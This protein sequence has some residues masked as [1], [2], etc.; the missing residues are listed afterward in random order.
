MKNLCCLFLALLLFASCASKSMDSQKKKEIAVATQRLGG[1]YYNSGNYTAALKT[2]LEAQETIPNDPYLNN[3]IGLVYLAKERYK[4]A[5]DSFKT[6]LTN[7]PDY[8]H[9]KNN[10]GAAYLKQKKWDLAIE[11]FKEVSENILYATPEM[12]LSNLG[13]VYFQKDMYK[14]AK[15]YFKQALDIKPDFLVALHGIASI[16][17]KMGHYSQALRFLHYNLM[18]KPGAAILHSDL[19]KTYEA[20]KQYRQAK[21]SWELVVKLAPSTSPLS[22][23]AKERI[24]QLTDF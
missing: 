5:E 11:C 10:L 16:Y 17:I 23:E 7:K 9:A 4:L 1:E 24:V 14:Q 22:R 15:S 3:S 8:I 13:W 18:Q 12:P 21:K 6:A 2:L 19:A 20:L